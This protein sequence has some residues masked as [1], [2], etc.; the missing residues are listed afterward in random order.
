V[1][2]T[3]LLDG[4]PDHKYEFPEPSIWPFVTAVCV[5]VLFI[6]SIFTP[7]GVV[8]GAIPSFI[9]MV[10]WFWPK[11]GMSPGDLEEC[12]KSGR[13]TPLELTH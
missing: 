11:K 12:I 4:E 13:A 9:A 1:L 6:W 8:W 3:H 2:V 5:S 7:W 10:L